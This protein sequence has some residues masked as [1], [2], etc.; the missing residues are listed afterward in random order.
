M[1]IIGALDDRKLLGAS[2][3]KPETFAAWRV[4]LKGLFALPMTKAEL[5]IYRAHTGRMEPPSAPHKEAWIV[6]G[7]RSGKSFI[8]AL[9]GVYLAAFRKYPELAPGEVGTVMLIAGDK[10]Q[11][12]VLMR[13][14]SGI[15]GASKILSKLIRKEGAQALELTNGIVIEI[16]T[17]SFRSI[18]GYSVVACLADEIAFWRSDESAN[19]DR[20]IVNAVRPSLATTNGLL[21][22]FST[23]YSRRGVLWEAVREYHG[24]ESDRLVWQAA[25]R[26]M[27]PMVPQRVI[28]DAMRD[29]PV[30]ASAEWLGQFRNDVD[31]FLRSE[32][33]D[34]AA[35]EGVHEIEPRPGCHYHAFT[36]PS[37]GGSDSFTL[38][39]CHEENGLFVIDLA[40]AWKP[41]FSPENVVGEIAAILRRY[42]LTSVFG[43]RYAGQWVSE[44][45][46]KQGIGYHH[47]SDKSSIYLESEP[48]FAT[49]KVRLIDNPAM[50]NELRQLERRVSPGGR[51]KVDHPPRGHD[52]LANA[53]CGALW[54]ANRAVRYAPG[55]GEVQV[56]TFDH[57]FLENPPLAPVA[58]GDDDFVIFTSGFA[59]DAKRDY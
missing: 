20:E 12:R 1:N 2:I 52:D 10:K 38:G 19:P 31:A 17:S 57:Q 16:H 44:A 39:V 5:E 4:F 33:L 7:R 30:A 8:S 37:G 58:H 29:D 51:D 21:L 56:A 6:A 3:R 42:G 14:T 22:G 40:R 50:M 48:L 45:F 53:A 9:I 11:A 36:D 26:E 25:T 59:S 18:R 55:E 43:D 49:G 28:D 15:F 46:L 13:Y 41:P 24:R 47:A 27:N 35:L 34:C 54:L 23:P 32:W